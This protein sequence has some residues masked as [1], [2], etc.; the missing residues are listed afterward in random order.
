MNGFLSD[1]DIIVEVTAILTFVKFTYVSTM[2]SIFELG[3]FK[4]SHKSSQLVIV[5]GIN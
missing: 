1:A 2:R 4:Q 3:I 5:S